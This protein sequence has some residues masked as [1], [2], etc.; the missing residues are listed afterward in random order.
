MCEGLFPQCLFSASANVCS[1][2]REVIWQKL[3]PSP[4]MDGIPYT[5]Q[6]AARLSSKFPLPM[7][8]LDPYLIH[9]SL[10]PLE[11][12]NPKG[13]SIG[14]A[15]FA[16]LTIMTV[17]ER[18]T[19]LLHLWQEVA[20]TYIAL[21]SDL[22]YFKFSSKSKAEKCENRSASGEV[23]PRVRWHTFCSQC[24]IQAL[25]KVRQSYNY[26]LLNLL[27]VFLWCVTFNQ[28]W[29]VLIPLAV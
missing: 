1:W 8:D 10:D 29:I 17:T 16:W 28:L 5:L 19:M 2:L 7:G 6:F 15:I 20:S 21:W 23:W 14:S 27:V 9:G 4:H 24:S 26:M 11:S 12:I 22:I 18:Q 3:V 13:I 25:V